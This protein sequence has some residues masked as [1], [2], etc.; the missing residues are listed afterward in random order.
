MRSGIPSQ[1][2]R[3]LGIGFLLAACL[4]LV[5]APAVQAKPGCGGKRAT[6]V[7]NAPRIVGTKAH[8]V[9]VAGS[10][11]NRIH[12]MGGNDTI[13]GGP[14]AHDITSYGGVGGP[15]SSTSAAAP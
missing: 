3:R 6:I 4:I 1:L 5:G 7:S 2:Q 13:D 15:I 10:R 12:G 8:N 14:G 9:I 11:A